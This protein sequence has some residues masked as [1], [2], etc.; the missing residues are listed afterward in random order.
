MADAP[1]L[2]SGGAILRGSSPL[3]GTISILEVFVDGIVEYFY[4]KAE[5]GGIKRK[6]VLNA[7][8]MRYLRSHEERGA[9]TEYLSTFRGNEP[10]A[11][12]NGFTPPRPF[13]RGKPI[14]FGHPVAKNG[15]NIQRTRGVGRGTS[16]G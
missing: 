7:F 5:S 8:K 1:D 4:W 11:C 6:D 3:P 12:P 14:G 16:G 10:G 15:S 9:F 13:L 2:G